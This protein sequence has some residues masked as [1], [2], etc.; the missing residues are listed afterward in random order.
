MKKINVG[1]SENYGDLLALLY[2]NMELNEKDL[3]TILSASWYQYQCVLK[4]SIVQA[5]RP[6]H[7]HWSARIS[8]L[9]IKFQAN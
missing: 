6:M 8:S 7:V 3:I 9:R 2:Q 5:L 4:L 1:L